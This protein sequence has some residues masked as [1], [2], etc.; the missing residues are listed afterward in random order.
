M[1]YQTRIE[2]MEEL[3]ERKE[4]ESERDMAGVA[5]VLILGSCPVV[6]TASLFAYYYPEAT[7]RLINGVVDTAKAFVGIP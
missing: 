2:A 4:I 7:S 5:I 1:A 3:V 6:G